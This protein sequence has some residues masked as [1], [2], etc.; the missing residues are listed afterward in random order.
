MSLFGFKQDRYCGVA[1]VTN[2]PWFNFDNS[3]KVS[4]DGRTF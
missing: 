3:I 1:L 2:L 4:T